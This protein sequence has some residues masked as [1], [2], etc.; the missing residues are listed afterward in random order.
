VAASM[1]PTS[2]G[3]WDMR[4]PGV[5]IADKFVSLQINAVRRGPQLALHAE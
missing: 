5:G 4:E 3:H 2:P 1:V